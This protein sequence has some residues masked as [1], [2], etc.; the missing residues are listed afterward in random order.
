MEENYGSVTYSPVS[1]DRSSSANSLYEINDNC[2][3]MPN[4]QVTAT[5]NSNVSIKHFEITKIL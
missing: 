3:E 4:T 1:T 5:D 2:A